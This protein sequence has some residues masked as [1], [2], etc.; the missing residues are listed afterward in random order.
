MSAFH[1]PLAARSSKGLSS[2]GV[3]EDNSFLLKTTQTFQTS[4]NSQTT[5]FKQFKQLQQF[6]HFNKSV[7]VVLSTVSICFECNQKTKS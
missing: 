4:Q 7:T 1:Q 2:G 3:G 6:K 5:H